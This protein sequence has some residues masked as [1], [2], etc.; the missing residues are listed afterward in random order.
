MVLYRLLNRGGYPDTIVFIVG[1]PISLVLLISHFTRSW[2]GDPLWH[3][4]F[5]INNV[6]IYISPGYGSFLTA[7]ASQLYHMLIYPGN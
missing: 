6:I 7:S 2:M 3:G 5:R 1:L 4:E